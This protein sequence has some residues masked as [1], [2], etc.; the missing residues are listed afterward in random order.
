[1]LLAK[2]E[3]HTLLIFCLVNTAVTSDVSSFMKTLYKHEQACMQRAENS[4]SNTA[5][6]LRSSWVLLNAAVANGSFD[7]VYKLLLSNVNQ[8]SC[9][10]QLEMTNRCYYMGQF[11]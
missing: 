1:M 5:S 3:K 10:L 2:L 8:M 11:S 9:I 4:G 6:S 7:D